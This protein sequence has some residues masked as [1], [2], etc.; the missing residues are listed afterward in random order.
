MFTWHLADPKDT[1]NVSQTL[2]NTELDEKRIYKKMAETFS[3]HKDIYSFSIVVLIC[4]FQL[5]KKNSH[6][7][8]SCCYHII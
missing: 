5:T 6:I 8:G 1:N 7:Y 3:T 2:Q 4:I